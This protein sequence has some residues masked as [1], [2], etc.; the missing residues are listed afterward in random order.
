[1]ATKTS[2]SERLAARAE[3]DAALNE[4]IESADAWGAHLERLTE[5]QARADFMGQGNGL[6][7]RTR[8]LNAAA[9]YHGARAR[10]L[11]VERAA[12]GA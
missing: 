10:R 2:Q 11:A 4:L 7:L 9:R 8:L 3:W 1:M 6:V 12:V 5:P